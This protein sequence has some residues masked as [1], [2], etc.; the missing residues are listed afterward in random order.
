MTMSQFADI[1]DLLAAL[2][3][4]NSLGFLAFELRK[5]SRQE[6]ISNWQSTMSGLREARRRTDDPH[7]A[8]VVTRGRVSFYDLSDQDRLTFGFWMEELLLA[9]DPFL[10]HPEQILV[11]P[12]AT[13]IA[14]LG[15]FREYFA[16]KGAR[17]WWLQSPVR[18]RW[19]PH[20][21]NVIEGAIRELEEV[22][23]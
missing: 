1:A 18:K 3:I 12:E 20:I 9:H 5:S 10:A 17:E 22:N 19:P 21:R 14:T 8:D 23:P 2:G 16:Q 11:S 6:R 13:R 15:A 7:V 4:I